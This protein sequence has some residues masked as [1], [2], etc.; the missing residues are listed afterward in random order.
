MC[1]LYKSEL[2]ELN[3]LEN[4]VVCSHHTDGQNQRTK[5]ER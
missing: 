2:I 4:A 1:A 3:E 5:N